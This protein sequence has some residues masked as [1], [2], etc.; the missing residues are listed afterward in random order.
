MLFL[1]VLWLIIVYLELS[2]GLDPM[3]EALRS[4]VWAVFFLEFGLRFV[5]APR[6]WLFLGRSW[7]SV[8][9]LTLPPLRVLRLGRVLRLLFPT[10][11]MHGFQEE[12]VAS[13]LAQGM[14]AFDAT[15]KRRGF[16]YVMIFTVVVLFAGAAGIYLFEQD[17]TGLHGF[18]SFGSALWWTG[19]TLVTM[20]SG[21]WPHSVEGRILGLLLSFYSFAIFAYII[22]SLTS[23]FL[24]RDAESEHTQVAGARGIDDLQHEIVLLRREL[25]NLSRKIEARLATSQH[26]QEEREEALKH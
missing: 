26:N 19:M 14:R 21:N 6:R 16:D 1:G 13:S 11:A 9:S 4:I 24:E 12:R 22:A 10:I 7:V 15:M 23:H 17:S 18:D 8:L 3:L 20:G 5:L 25:R 2:F